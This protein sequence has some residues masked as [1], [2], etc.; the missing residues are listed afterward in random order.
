MSECIYEIILNPYI[1]VNI[2]NHS[3]IDS[4]FLADRNININNF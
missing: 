2:N 4:E 3:V 1:N